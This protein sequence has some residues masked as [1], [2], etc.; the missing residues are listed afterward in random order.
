MFGLLYGKDAMVM[1]PCNKEQK[2]DSLPPCSCLPKIWLMCTVI[3]RHEQ[4]ITS[5]GTGCGKTT[6]CQKWDSNPRLQGRL[7]PER[8]A[9]DRSAILTARATS[10]P[11]RA[12]QSRESHHLQ[13]SQRAQRNLKF[14]FNVKKSRGSQWVISR[15]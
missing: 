9:L 14:T 3:H 12:S 4:H 7:R 2:N 13:V 6:G 10:N 5:Q 1:Y 15:C 11:S 8:S